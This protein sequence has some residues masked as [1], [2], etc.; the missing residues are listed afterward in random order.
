MKPRHLLVV[1][2]LLAAA[3]L[4]AQ[5]PPAVADLL[6]PIPCRLIGCTATLVAEGVTLRR[7]VEVRAE[8]DGVRW[9]LPRK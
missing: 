9:A 5:Q 8:R 6:R 1:A 4:H 3:G 2:G 7:A